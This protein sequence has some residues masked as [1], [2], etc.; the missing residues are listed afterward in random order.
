MSLFH[1]Q[2]ANTASF[3]LRT[4][5]LEVLDNL[6][7]SVAGFVPRA[8]T[9]VLVILIG[10]LLAKLAEKMIRTA[11][12]KF[13][14][15]DLL[16]RVGAS[17]NLRKIGLQGTPGRLLSRT[18]Y[19]LLIILFTQSVTRAVGLDAIADAIGAFFRYLPNL[20][21]A[22]LVL[23]L[24]MIVSQFLAGSVT[25]SAQESGI[26]FAPVLGRLV[27]ALILFVVI[28]MAISQLKID[29]DL[30]KAVVLVFLGGLS[31]ALALSFGLGSR[32]VTRN[33]VAG[34]YARKLFRIGEKVE[35]GGEQGILTAITPVQSLIER[36]GETV[37][38]PNRQFVE[39]VVKH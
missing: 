12:D 20:A 32:E 15:N 14:L 35:V 3:D 11:F 8:I 19:F 26:E 4:A 7:Q 37:A 22:F 17:N 34:F 2:T 36:D 33:L 29:T 28:I 39:E 5:T 30:I 6:V 23:F 25:R 24:G 18:V 16:D 27:A 31:M 9:A 10:L 38:I 21:A 13:R 1:L